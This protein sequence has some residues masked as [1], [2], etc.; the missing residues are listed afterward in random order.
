M[1][2]S[3]RSALLAGLCLLALALPG[4]ARAGDGRLLVFAAA[5]LQE[6]LDRAVLAWEQA[7]GRP[8]AVSYAGSATLARQ[9]ERGA[10][11]DLFISADQAW[12]DHLQ[13]RG[14][15]RAGDRRP[16]VGNRLVLVAPAAAPLTTLPLESDALLA[17]LG[18]NGRLA[19]AE[20]TSVPA[21]RH[22]RQALEHLG[23]WEALSGRLAEGDSV[24]AAL[25]F[26][27]RREAPLGIVYATDARAEPRVRVLADIPASQHAPIVYPMARIAGAGK[28]AQALARFLGG[29][30]AARIFA[31]AGF[32]RP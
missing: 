16:L 21:G 13:A 14:Y 28:D 20:T 8:V 25:A 10:P 31:D 32:T 30:Q 24:R 1:C 6:A 15:V 12:M 17:A 29:E 11:A 4:G 7:G 22:A 27:A 26:V 18:E 9:I 19:V 3:F 5:S 2:S 23:A